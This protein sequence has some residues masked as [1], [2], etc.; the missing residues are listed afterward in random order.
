MTVD[1]LNSDSSDQG[2]EKGTIR[3]PVSGER[4]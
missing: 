2:D 1:A 3:L 4:S